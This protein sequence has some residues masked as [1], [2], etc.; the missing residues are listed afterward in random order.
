MRKGVAAMLAVLFLASLVGCAST[1]RDEGRPLEVVPTVDLLRY[2]GTWYEIASYPNS[3]QRGCTAT[4]ATY[5]LLEDGRVEVLN[6]CRRGSLEG[7]LTTARGKAKVVDPAT[8]AKLKVTFFWPFYGDYWIIDL[9]ED[10]E[11]AVVGH[12]NRQYLWILSRTPRMDE[13]LYDRIL[14]RLTTKQAYDV[15]K[16]VKTAQQA[17]P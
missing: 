6:E 11:Y 9:G 10:Y 13:A 1:G 8:R 2:M 4:R 7:E 12:P 15:T 14:E 17:R 5:R 16:L 3:F